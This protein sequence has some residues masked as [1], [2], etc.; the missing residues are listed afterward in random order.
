MTQCIHGIDIFIETNEGNERSR[1]NMLAA[2]NKEYFNIMS[3]IYQNEMFSYCEANL[4]TTIHNDSKL[5]YIFFD[6]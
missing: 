3:D 2:Q 6:R 4:T 1:T 5:Y